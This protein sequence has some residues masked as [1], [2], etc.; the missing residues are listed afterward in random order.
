MLPW[1][2]FTVTMKNTIRPCC[3]FPTQEAVDMENYEDA[4]KNLREDMLAGKKDPRCSKCFEEEA[5]GNPSMRTSA[6]EFHGLEFKK[7][8]LTS[9]FR[10]LT[11]I[12]LS[13]DNT[14][15]LQCRMCSSQF[16]SKLL[17]RDQW[18]V[19]NHEHLDFHVAKVQKSRYE[20]L[21]DL[22]IDW[23]E[24]RSVKLLGGEPFLSP[25]FLDF[26]YFLDM[27]TDISQVQLEI[28]TN[29]TTQLTEEMVEILNQF[30]FIRL[31]GS[32]DGLPKHNEYQRV[33]SVWH[34]GLDN[35]IE[36][37][38][39]LK[40]R[41]LT[42]HQTFTVFN[43]SHLDEALSLYK[44]YCDTQ[45]WSYDD[46]QFSF[47]HAPDWFEEWVLSRNDNQKLQNIFKKRKYDHIKWHRLLHSIKTLD[48]YYG[49]SLERSNPELAT[50]LRINTKR[51]VDARIRPETRDCY[52]CDL[53]DEM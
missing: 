21:K 26:L 35:F 23:S 20:T 25:N 46:Y 31:S 19:N 33:G 12:E 52:Y 15:N 32:F 29:C 37:G 16:S 42:I 30:K 48:D 11:H 44:P 50:A 4:F 13:L 14:C 2:S 28:V 8:H 18:L 6:N 49:T 43:I 39:Q 41:R 36:Y 47:L 5:S 24:L 10:K 17:K 40:N 45:S 22:N 9:D 34:K 3:R 51:Y 27:R 53:I 7:E 1:E 38:E